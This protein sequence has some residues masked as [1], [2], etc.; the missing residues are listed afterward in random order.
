LSTEA[1]EPQTCEFVIQGRHPGVC[2]AVF[3]GI[4]GLHQSLMIMGRYPSLCQVPVENIAD[5]FVRPVGI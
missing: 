4:D 3:F 2:E 5:I 1:S